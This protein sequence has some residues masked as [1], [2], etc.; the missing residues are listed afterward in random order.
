MHADAIVRSVI[1]NLAPDP[2]HPVA[3][4]LLHRSLSKDLREY[5]HICF[6]GPHVP[7]HIL[8]AAP[9]SIACE[10]VEHYATSVAHQVHIFATVLKRGRQVL[11]IHLDGAFG[12][13]EMRVSCRGEAKQAA[14]ANHHDSRTT[15]ETNQPN[16]DHYRAHAN[17]YGSACVSGVDSAQGPPMKPTNQTTTTT[18]QMLFGMALPAY[19]ELTALKDH[20]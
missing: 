13:H 4:L 9:P 16:N 5:G 17:W 8:A 11:V 14:W 6:S 18:V 7:A 19:L 3:R 12:V 20:Q 15:N 1:R 2:M 10:G